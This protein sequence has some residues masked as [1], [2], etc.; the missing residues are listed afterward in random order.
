[1][2]K[3][4]ENV[5]KIVEVI[6]DSERHFNRLQHQY[7]ALASAWILAMFAGIQYVLSN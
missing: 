2:D 7:R 6:E 4:D 3:F 1:M 5:W